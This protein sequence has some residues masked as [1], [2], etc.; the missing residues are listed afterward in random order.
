M[1]RFLSK[2]IIE[3]F[4]KGI[5][6]KRK[7]NQPMTRKEFLNFMV[8][9]LSLVGAMPYVSLLDRAVASNSEYKYFIGVMAHT[10]ALLFPQRAM[11][12]QNGFFDGYGNWKFSGYGT[13]SEFDSIK[14]HIFVPRGLTFRVNNEIENVGHFLAQGAF[15]SGYPSKSATHSDMLLGSSSSSLAPANVSSIDW[16]IARNKGFQP[17]A[18]GYRDRLVYNGAEAPH[19]FRAISWIGPDKPHYPVFDSLALHNLVKNQLSCS[20]YND[21]AQSSESKI[22]DLQNQI[23]LMSLLEKSYANHLRVDRSYSDTYDIYIQDF[24]KQS[25]TYQQDINNL[26]SNINAKEKLASV[27]D[28]V[29]PKFNIPTPSPSSEIYYSSKLAELGSFA[30][31]CLKAG[32]T[33]SVSMS[34]CLESNHHRQHYIADADVGRDNQTRENVISHGAGLKKY[35]NVVAKGMIDLV[36]ELKRE[37]IFH[38]TLILLCGEQND[39]NVHNAHEAPVLIIDGKNGSWNG[40]NIGDPSLSRVVAGE[41]RPYSDLL[42]DILKKFGHSTTSFGSPHNIKGIGRG[43]IF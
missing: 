1:K 27:C 38:E 3:L 43:G 41:S 36:N 20:L 30:A 2:S 13:L 10:L 16:I 8:R 17:L 25:Q 14:S 7:K 34:I 11:T 22:A 42:V 15:L 31:R 35:M 40:R 4:S 5:E 29:G 32:L 6:M 12:L 33:N 21:A 9:G 37:E 23:K 18:L 24:K 28:W 19:F 39:G 26:S